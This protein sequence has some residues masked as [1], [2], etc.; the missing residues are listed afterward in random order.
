MSLSPKPL[1]QNQNFIKLWVS[2]TVSI[3]GTQIASLAYPLTAILILHVSPFQMGLLRMSGSASAVLVGFFAG[4]IVDRVNRRSL[5]IFA[6]LGRALLAALIPAA[7]FL[8]IL[9]IEYLFIITFCTGALNILSEVA[10]MAFLPS[11]VEKENLVE[12]NSKFA[13]TDSVAGIA[14]P[15]LSGLLV[16]ILSAPITIVIDSVS[17][18]FSAVLVSLIQSPE[19]PKIEKEE[20][21]G[22]W[23][24]IKEGLKFVYGNPVLRPLAESVALHFLFMLIISTV[25]LLYA[26]QEL[27]LE[28]F[29][30]GVIFSAFGFG[31]LLAAL[32][33]KRLTNRFGRGKIMVGAT[34]INALAALLIPLASGYSAVF[35]LFAA[36]FILAFGIQINGINLMSLRQALT[37]DNLQGRMNGTFR[38]INVCMMMFGALIAGLLGEW[39]G[40]RTT[41]IIG[42]IGMFLPF[43]R[44]LFSPV[45]DIRS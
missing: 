10:S 4:V 5:L 33:V 23:S 35:I 2:Q 32:F 31:F 11:L 13:A 15:N 19:L 7:A 20:K 21:K 26:V 28:P 29:H 1:R 38:F 8:N 34:L 25:F 6:D 27:Q 18:I 22:V 24:Q 44:L 43:L 37:P 3:F 41:L 12:G 17:F 40:L 36:H 14:G 16:Q 45:R 39:I 42:A 30:L 9:R